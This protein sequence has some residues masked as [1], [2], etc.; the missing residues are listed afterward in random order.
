MVSKSQVPL[1][2]AASQVPSLDPAPLLHSRGEETPFV[3]S[4]RTASDILL[5]Q[6]LL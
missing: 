5:R 3:D 4:R 6:T 2:R 1:G